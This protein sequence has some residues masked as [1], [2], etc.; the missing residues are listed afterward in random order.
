MMNGATTST[1]RVFLLASIF[2]S[3]LLQGC[4]GGLPEVEDAG[5]IAE[6]IR[7]E[8]LGCEDYVTPDVH[9]KGEGM[10]NSGGSCAVKGEGIQI[11]GFPSEE[12]TDLWFE[13]GRMQSV[14]TVRGPNWVVVTQ[15]Q[16]VADH[17]AELL[18]R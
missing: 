9:G 18:K 14:P 10:A 6:R 11:F 12:D 15:S 13:R 17:I 5:Q 3:L 7:S 16:E 4:S 8:G 2:L 1:R